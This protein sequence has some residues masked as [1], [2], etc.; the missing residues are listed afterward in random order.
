MKL[1]ELLPKLEHYG[2]VTRESWRD[3]F[4][5]RPTN[6]FSPLV[7]CDMNSLI[8]EAYCLSYHDLTSDDW[9]ILK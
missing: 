1:L 8:M 2:R 6:D 3:W 7:R 5:V 4:L 9:E